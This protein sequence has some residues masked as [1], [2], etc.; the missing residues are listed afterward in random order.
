MGIRKKIKEKEPLF[1][2]KQNR[3]SQLSALR[4]KWS[5]EAFTSPNQKVCKGSWPKSLLFQGRGSSDWGDVTEK[6]S[7]FF[8]NFNVL[9]SNIAASLQRFKILSLKILGLCRTRGTE[10]LPVSNA[11]WALSPLFKFDSACGWTWRGHKKPVL[12]SGACGHA[13]FKPTKVRQSWTRGE[14]LWQLQ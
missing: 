10:N 8:E 2:G 4:N 12:M 7:N 1:E 11:R 14:L 5:L 3:S 6:H 9:T 13:L